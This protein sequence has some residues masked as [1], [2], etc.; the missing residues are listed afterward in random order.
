M[1]IKPDTEKD[2]ESRKC[3]WMNRNRKRQIK[4]QQ[5]VKKAGAFRHGNSEACSKSQEKRNESQFRIS[6]SCRWQSNTGF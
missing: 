1:E 2:K 6:G 3:M 4:L 5:E